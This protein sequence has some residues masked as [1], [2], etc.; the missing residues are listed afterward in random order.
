M[1][2]FTPLHPVVAL[3]SPIPLRFRRTSNRDRLSYKQY[4]YCESL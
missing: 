3:R 2:R 1:A 4:E